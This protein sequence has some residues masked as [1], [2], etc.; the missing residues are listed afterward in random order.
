MDLGFFRRAET[1]FAGRSAARL[2]YG[3][4]IASLDAH[5]SASATARAVRSCAGRGA[6]DLGRDPV[7]EL[8]LGG[9]AWREAI[10]AQGGS[11]NRPLARQREKAS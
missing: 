9:P 1:R 11:F 8:I 4:L 10:E 6:V 3:V 5:Q 2:D 7:V